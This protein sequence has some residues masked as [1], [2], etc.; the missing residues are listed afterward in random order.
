[1]RY[2]Y[3]A[4]ARLLNPEWAA[5]ISRFKGVKQFGFHSGQ[6]RSS[7][8]VVTPAQLCKCRTCRVNQED[9]RGLCEGKLKSIRFN[10]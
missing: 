8:L 5:E 1:M 10:R 6:R 4:D 7:A 2:H 3:A 9:L